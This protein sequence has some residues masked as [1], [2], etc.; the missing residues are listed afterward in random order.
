MMPSSLRFLFRAAL[1]L[2]LAAAMPSVAVPQ[3]EPLTP[4]AE[5]LRVFLDCHGPCDF[6][7]IRREITY[8]NWVRDRQDAD[9]HLLL[10][11]RGTGGGGQEYTLKSIG[12]RAFAGS[13]DEFIFNS[14]QSDT[15]DEIRALIVQR[16][17]LG[18]ARFAARGPFAGRL[19]LT[20]EAPTGADSAAAQQQ[21][22]DPWNLW[23]FTLGASGHLQLESQVRTANL[24]GSFRARRITEK[25][26][27]SASLRGNRS[28]TR[29]ELDSGEVVHS[30]RSDYTLG[31][32][33]VRSLG[34]HW[35]FGLNGGGRRSSR[36]NYDMLVRMAP[37]LEYD[38]FPYAESSRREFVFV[39]E[40]GLI[41]A[42]Y[43][44]ETIFSKLQETR[45]NQALTAAVEAVQPWG[46][47]EARVT[48]SSYLDNWSQNRVILEGG[49][50]L[51]IVRGLDLNLN[52]EY[53]RVRDQLSLAKEGATDDEVLLQLKQL[54][55]SYEFFGSIGLSFTFG[56]K[57][58]N[59]VNPRFNSSV[60]DF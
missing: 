36:D 40:I 21:Q 49:L 37:G 48:G 47:V 38:V 13:E 51:R 58:N 14:R 52:A 59:V 19:R 2:C 10:T 60:F 39:Y 1:G 9:V 26:K 16:I 8:V 28:T 43:A 46:S 35:S 7:F 44:E 50:R 55:T 15:F 25:W 22:R 24:S 32:L 6:D 27:L 18:L 54:K 20:F 11:T 42:K 5:I 31:L 12:L 41:H 57:F 56:S 4:P 33:A 34:A 45:V 30:K 17:G 23:V 3:D 29:F 53:A